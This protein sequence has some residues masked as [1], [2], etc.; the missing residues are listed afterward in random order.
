MALFDTDDHTPSKIDWCDIAIF[1]EILIIIGMLWW[2]S[3]YI[4]EKPF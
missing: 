2:V 3:G 4:P 1:L